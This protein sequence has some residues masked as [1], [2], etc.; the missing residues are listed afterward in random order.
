M[1]WILKKTLPSVKT[2]KN[3]GELPNAVKNSLKTI[4]NSSDLSKY[5]INLE[6]NSFE[7]DEVGLHN[8]I[9]DNFHS[10]GLVP[11]INISMKKL[12]SFLEKKRTEFKQLA[13]EYNKK[14]N[15]YKN[16]KNKY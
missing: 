5:I 2:I 8:E 10:A 6:K 15:E 12:N 4:V 14:I 9:L 16:I 7:F 3:F 1:E 13:N 11:D